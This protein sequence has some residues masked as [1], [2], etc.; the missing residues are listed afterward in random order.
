MLN[1]R[2]QGKEVLCSS[3]GRA[4]QSKDGN[5]TVRSKVHGKKLDGLTGLMQEVSER[6][7]AHTVVRVIQSAGPESC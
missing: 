3:N 2:L 7:V 1:K 6:C 5:S 4:Q